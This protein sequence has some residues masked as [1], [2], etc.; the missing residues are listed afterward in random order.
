MK[1]ITLS[2]FIKNKITYVQL[3]K[4]TLSRSNI[5]TQFSSR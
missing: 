4:N 3:H 5:I 2:L 1:L